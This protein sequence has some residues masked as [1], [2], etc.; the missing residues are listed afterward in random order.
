MRKLQAMFFEVQERI[1]TAI[2]DKSWDVVNKLRKVS[3]QMTKVLNSG[4][5]STAQL[6][7]FQ[8]I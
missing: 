5:V 7:Q 4:K 6:E 8:A 3:I 2:F 1:E